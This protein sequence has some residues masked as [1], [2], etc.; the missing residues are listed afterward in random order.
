MRGVI[1][2]TEGTE[3]TEG[4]WEI[5]RSAFSSCSYYLC[6]LC[7]L[8]GGD[9]NFNAEAQGCIRVPGVIL[10]TE[11]TESTEGKWG[12]RRS[13][14]SSCSFYLC[15]LCGGDRNFNAEARG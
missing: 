11:G 13:A 15:E 10:T 4:K 3:S 7:D 12:I 14:F 1:L 9:R 8:R 6:E 5:R 2:T